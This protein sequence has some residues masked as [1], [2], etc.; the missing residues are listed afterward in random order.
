MAI[1]TGLLSTINTDTPYI[2]VILY[3]IILGLGIGINMPIANTNIQN[4]VQPWQ[5][6]SATSTVQFFRNI[7]STIGSAIYGTIMMTAMNTGFSKL[8]ISNIPDNVQGML[9]NPQIITNSESVKHIAK[10]VP[11]KYSSFFS[12]ALDQAKKVLANSVHEIFVFCMIA[13]IF[14]IILTLFFKDAPLRTK[15]FG[16]HSDK[17]DKLF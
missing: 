6:G 13:A 1:G 12:S 8:N 15:K 11:A 16:G 9:K 7:G 14:G 17:N 4:S 5:I 10:Q 2:K 3:M